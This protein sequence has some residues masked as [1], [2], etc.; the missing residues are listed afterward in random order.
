MNRTYPSKL[1]DDF[2]KFEKK[3]HQKLSNISPK[4]VA[5]YFNATE[6]TN[7]ITFI[8]DKYDTVS[9]AVLNTDLLKDQVKKVN[10]EDFSEALQESQHQK[11]M[12]DHSKLL[13]GFLI[14]GSKR[15]ELKKSMSSSFV[16]TEDD[17]ID[18]FHTTSMFALTKIFQGAC[19]DFKRVL[20]VK[21]DAKKDL[22]RVAINQSN[23]IVTDDD[24]FL[25]LTEEQEYHS[26]VIPDQDTF[27]VGHA[28]SGKSVVLRNQAAYLV[29]HV[30]QAKILFLCFNRVLKNYMLDLKGWIA[31][32]P[33]VSIETIRSFVR[34]GSIHKYD[35]I[36]VDEGQ[37]CSIV[38]LKKVKSYLHDHGHL[39]MAMDGGQNLYNQEGNLSKAGIFKRTS[40]IIELKS[41]YR[42][43]KQIYMMAHLFLG[44]SK[45]NITNSDD[46]FNYDYITDVASHYKEGPPVTFE[47][48]SDKNEFKR[49]LHE[50]TA[51]QESGVDNKQIAILINR[52]DD[53]KAIKETINQLGLSEAI[54]NFSSGNQDYALRASQVTV[55]TAHQSKGLEFDY[56]FYCGFKEGVDTNKGYLKAAYVAMTRAKKKLYIY[57]SVTN[58]IVECINEAVKESVSYLESIKLDNLNVYDNKRQ[59]HVLVMDLRQDMDWFEWHMI[60]DTGEQTIPILRPTPKPPKRKK[61]THLK[62]VAALACVLIVFEII[63][64]KPAIEEFLSELATIIKSAEEPN[65]SIEEVTEEILFEGIVDD[66][67]QDI[68]SC[69]I[70]FQSEDIDFED[71]KFFFKVGSR[72][73]L[74]KESESFYLQVCG[75][76][77]SKVS[78]ISTAEYEEH[79]F[80][81]SQDFTFNIGNDYFQ[82]ISFGSHENTKINQIDKQYGQ[83]GY[84]FIFHHQE[85]YIQ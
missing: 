39:I 15:H 68:P 31:D 27:I 63:Q 6:K 62:V 8:F 16:L 84:K 7:Y 42:T 70:T 79:L 69:Y 18:F 65:E 32:K 40:K 5:V 14:I 56:V 46:I 37:D 30:P 71:N 45:L 82:V 25:V 26:Q 74:Y 28:G 75:Y 23:Q 81:I 11:L 49:V 50:V 48:V 55:A 41:N 3:L 43:T 66:F 21:D 2:S 34:S 80:E 4:E 29:E 54:F 78:K 12:A 61:K 72:I 38:E 51:L 52:N 60:L 57:Y 67:G 19:N 83:G 33:N 53:A 22:L 10:R 24:Q 1:L 85:G 77:A 76:R 35:Y 64:A 59:K 58:I 44:N 9:L 36:F 73:K 47:P 13:K 20:V 17:F